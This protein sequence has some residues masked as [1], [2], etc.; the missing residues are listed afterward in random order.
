MQFCVEHK[1]AMQ[2][3]SLMFVAGTMH[4]YAGPDQLR[5]LHTALHCID[6]GCHL[7]R[8]QAAFC[9]IWKLQ[10]RC[11]GAVIKQGVESVIATMFDQSRVPHQGNGATY[12]WHNSWYV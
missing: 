10:H 11:I 8:G 7:R 4:A 6:L 1:A 12:G 5:G 9:C 2:A 3:F